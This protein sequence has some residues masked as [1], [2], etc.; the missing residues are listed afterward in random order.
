MK[1]Q[2]VYV[3]VSSDND[4]YLEE[5]WASLYSLRHFHPEANVK[6]L[7]DS[8]TVKRLQKHGALLAMITDLITVDVPE[9][10]T[11]KER[12]RQIK[13]TVRQLIEGPYLFIDT[14]TI[15]C[16][17]LDEMDACPYDLAA[18]PDGHLPLKEHLFGEQIIANV[19]RLFGVNVSDSKNWYNSGVMYVADTEMTHEFYKRWNI[20]WKHS[21]F[22]KGFS[23]DQPALVKT[24]KEFGYVIQHLQD[25]MNCQV[26]MSLKYFADAMIVHFWHMS[27]IE[28]QSYSPYFGLS[29][30]REIKDANAI[31]PHVQELILNC[32]STFVSPTM[33]VG[34]D[35]IL[36]LFSPVGRIF[37]RIHKEGGPASYLMHKTASLLKVLHSYFR[38]R[39]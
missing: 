37:N 24:D 26:A 4:L 38:E 12:S 21:S 35:Q 1:S 25:V 10:Y 28:D 14:D 7:A 20:N 3:L 30:Y 9:E 8:P 15:V 27:F 19:Q 5:L 11:P 16:H 2:I 36:F 6:V 34:K 39:K 23:Q 22:D 13:T 33:P 32:K 17:P 31:T 18:V 29:I